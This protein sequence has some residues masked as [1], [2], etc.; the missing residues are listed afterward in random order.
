MDGLVSLAKP[1]DA[2]TK[3]GDKAGEDEAEVG[4]K[5]PSDHKHTPKVMVKDQI[6]HSLKLS[7]STSFKPIPKRTAPQ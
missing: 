2:D 5:G 1:L 7:L 4:K 6:E 3:N